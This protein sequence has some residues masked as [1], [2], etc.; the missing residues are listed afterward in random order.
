MDGDLRT[1]LQ[2]ATDEIT[3]I[4]DIVYE[5]SLKPNH[6]MNSGI[7]TDYFDWNMFYLGIPEK[8]RYRIRQREIGTADFKKKLIQRVDIMPCLFHAYIYRKFYDYGVK[9]QVYKFIFENASR[10]SDCRERFMKW[11]MNG[12]VPFDVIER[13]Q[14]RRLLDVEVINEIF[15]SR[16]P[17]SEYFTLTPAHIREITER[18]LIDIAKVKRKN[19]LEMWQFIQEV[20]LKLIHYPLVMTWDEMY[21]YYLRNTNNSVAALDD[22]RYYLD[23]GRGDKY[24]FDLA[25]M[26]SNYND[27]SPW[28][29]ISKIKSADRQKYK[30][31]Q[32]PDTDSF[33]WKQQRK[34]MKHYTAP[35]FTFVIDYFFAG[36]YRYLLA[37]NVNTRKAFY[38]IPD[39]I[40][41]LGHNWNIRGKR[42][43]WNVSSRSAINSLTHIMN[44]TEVRALI[45]D[46]EGAFISD[47]FKQFLRSNNISFSYV[48]KYNVGKIIETQEASRSTHTT[49]L[50][51]RLCRTLRQMNNNLGNVNEI[52]PP[53]MN[54]LIDEYNNSVH[55]TLSKI[56]KRKVTPNEVDSDIRLETELV[57]CIRRKNFIVENSEDYIIKD[58][59]K[60]RVYNDSNHMDKVKPKLLPGTW[61]FV[62]RDG[63]LYK[64]K[65]GRVT[66]TVPRWMLSLRDEP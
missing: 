9:G 63:G 34:L 66:I 52:N 39:E 18:E 48:P 41:K 38:A 42:G 16:K 8:Y 35:R 19:A 55:T 27:K 53:M 20:S 14:K 13:I 36:R 45:M 22:A 32:R 30:E 12:S 6:L 61:E 29:S 49:S 57:K 15:R 25:A 50:V 47:A 31:K 5:Y 58:D 10:I 46:N 17:N 56:L 4:I 33:N 43:E 1:P 54:Y 24:A 2:K 51:D 40:R 11:R 37:I 21:E 3:R 28:K 7:D 59:A 26:R 44:N 64:V 62:E 65:Q 23:N 60:L